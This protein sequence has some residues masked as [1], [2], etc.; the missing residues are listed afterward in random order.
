MAAMAAVGDARARLNDVVNALGK[1]ADEVER[2]ELAARALTIRIELARA[3][4]KMMTHQ[5]AATD[6]SGELGT[7]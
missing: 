1:T 7:I 4:E 5:I 6:T 2:K 3:W